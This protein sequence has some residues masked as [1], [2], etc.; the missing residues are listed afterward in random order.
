MLRP[1]LG[2]ASLS[3]RRAFT[4]TDWFRQTYPVTTG[5]IVALA[6][7]GEA[8]SSSA[9]VGAS[10][11]AAGRTDLRRV[12]PYHVDLC[13]QAGFIPMTSGLNP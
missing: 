4:E 9:A 3:L 12:V 2:G 6:S 5:E 7:D 8:A 11:D 10:G 1:S 13:E